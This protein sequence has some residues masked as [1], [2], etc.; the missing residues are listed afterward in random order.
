MVTN[1]NKFYFVKE[2]DGC[3]DIAAAHGIS[4]SDLYAWNAALKGDCS[5]LWS[6]VYVCVGLAG[7]PSATTTSTTTAPGN[8]I[9]TPTLT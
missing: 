4:L 8:G 1:C 7:A 6:N 3:Y 9:S 2:N 5:G